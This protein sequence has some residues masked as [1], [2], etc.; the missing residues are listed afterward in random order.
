MSRLNKAQFERAVSIEEQQRRRF[1]RKRESGFVGNGYW[2]ANYPYVYGTM[3]TGGAMT[4]GD[5]RDQ[6]TA[7]TDV[8]MG[9]G[10]TSG[11]GAY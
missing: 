9:E 10:G 4:S 11:A 7:N 1:G 3:G 8:A 2:W 5:P 6:Q